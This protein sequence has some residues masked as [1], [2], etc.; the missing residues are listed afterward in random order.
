MR[1]EIT[2]PN[3]RVLSKTKT[4]WEMNGRS[5]TT[6]RADVRIAG[7]VEKIRLSEELYDVVE[8][9]KD[10]KLAGTLSIAGRNVGFVFDSVARN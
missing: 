10:Y 1:I 6:Y 2:V 8:I 9:D 7:E 4:P 5:G 3:V